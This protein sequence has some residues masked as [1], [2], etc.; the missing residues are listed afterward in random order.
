VRSSPSSSATK[1]LLDAFSN[2]ISQLFY[3]EPGIHICSGRP[4][5]HDLAHP[6]FAHLVGTPLEQIEEQLEVDALVDSRQSVFFPIVVAVGVAF[7]A[8]PSPGTATKVSRVAEWM[9]DAILLLSALIG[10]FCV[11]VMRGLRWLAVSFFLVEECLLFGAM[12]IAGMAISG[13]WI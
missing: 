13:D 6:Q 8:Q 4:W 7:A 5:V 9:L 1:S 3:L 12:F 11:Y 2:A 10:I